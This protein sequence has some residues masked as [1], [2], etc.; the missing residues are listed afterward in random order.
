MANK[1]TVND[2]R[3]SK[4]QVQEI[5]E[6]EGVFSEAYSQFFEEVYG[7]GFV[8]RDLIYELPGDKFLFVFDS[9]GMIVPGKGDIY[10]GEYFRKWVSFIA[11][12]KE[13][14]AFG[15]GSS[16]DHWHYYSKLQGNLVDHIEELI[17][18]LA[19]RLTISIQVLDKSYASLAVLSSR[20]EKFG[21]GNA[22][23]ELY[24]N[25]VAYVGEVLRLRVNGVWKVRQLPAGDY[26]FPSI[27][28]EG[29]GVYYSAINVVWGALNSIEIDLRAET[30][31]VVRRNGWQVKHRRN[32]K[33]MKFKGG[34]DSE[35]GSHFVTP[36]GWGEWE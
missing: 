16:L 21:R 6:T 13:S 20:I 28:I 31:Q 2:K 36:D 33:R 30:A 23:S 12:A 3:L 29:L 8:K 4:K 25:L 22:F 32:N 26:V 27:V 9:Y 7:S 34:Y 19:D 35:T 18:A 11:W 17:L 1:K 14:N 10:P 24:D 5:M 15:R